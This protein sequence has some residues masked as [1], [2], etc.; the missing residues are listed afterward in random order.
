MPDAAARRGRGWGGRGAESR[1]RAAAFRAGRRPRAW[2][3]GEE[4]RARARA[5]AAAAAAMAPA[6]VEAALA[7]AGLEMGDVHVYVEVLLV[8][9]IVY[10]L[11]Q[12]SYGKGSRA[13]KL[14]AKEMDALVAEWEP[15][16]LVSAE[17]EERDADLPHEPV[18]S[19]FEGVRC[20]ADG[21]E[22][23]NFAAFNFLGLGGDE[24]SVEVSKETVDKYG[25]GSCGPRGFYGTIDVHID[26]ET[27]LRDFSGAEE[28]ILYAYDMAAPAS[29]IPTFAKKG[30][31]LVCDEQVNWALQNGAVLS[32]S[33]VHYYKHNDM[34]D[35]E[36][37][38][39]KLNAR[40]KGKP[41]NRRFICCEGIYAKTGKMVPLD[42]VVELK[43][44]YKFR[45]IL[46]D[47]NS[48][49]VLGH[50]GRGT[51]EHFGIPITDIDIVNVNLGNALGSIGAMVLGSHKVIDHQRLNG[52]GYVFSASLPPFLASAAIAAIERL[53]EEPQLVERLQLNI[54]DFLAALSA[55]AGGSIA[56][57]S[58][59]QSAIVVMRLAAADGSDLAGEE[60]AVRRAAELCLEQ[61]VLVTTWRGTKLDR[62]PTR[63]AL[64]AC[65][66]AA[67]SPQQVKSAARAIASA[68]T[69]AAR[70][71]SLF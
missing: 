54:T 10:L 56:V 22:C 44:K 70:E 33:E 51:A 8:V 61:G 29:V 37:L 66:S 58:C 45:C 47:S 57:E 55:E 59:E 13:Q 50:K 46:D 42:R 69:R 25:V 52:A 5:R 18:L 4:G 24:R 1:G 7:F 17:D 27:R 65:V 32:R 62:M 71:V 40:D 6:I 15:E 68:Y 64:R 60:A 35:L 23:T 53:D 43:R 49:G 12:R 21:K 36:A 19:E 34:A 9:L 2:G 38:L 48:L 26:L 39:A 3:W 63:P 11:A 31:L 20:V 41:I 16:P 67:H 28:A 14:S 30:D